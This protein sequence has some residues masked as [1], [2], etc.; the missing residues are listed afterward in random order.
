MSI[1]NKIE[2][3][4][5]LTSPLHCSTADSDKGKGDKNFT[6]TQKQYILTPNGSQQFPFFPGNDLRGRLR[7]KAAKIIMESLVKKSKISVDLYS[8]LSAGTIHASP[9]STLS[10]E[11][12]LRARDNVYMGLFGGGT[13]MLRSRYRVNDLI[14]VARGTVEA[15]V[16]PT[17]V[18]DFRATIPAG[19]I[20]E[21][22][23]GDLTGYQLCNTRTSFRI[24]DVTRV[25]SADDINKYI[26]DAVGAVAAKQADN[27]ASRAER[28]DS[29]AK[30]KD[31]EIPAR[32][33]MKKE[34]TSN[35][36]VVESIISGTDMHFLLDF[37]NDASDEHVGMMLLSLQDLVRE[38]GLGGWVRIGFGRFNADVVLTRNGRTYKIFKDGSN[39]ADATLTDEVMESFVNKALNAVAKLTA[40][41]LMEFFTNKKPVKE[42]DMP[43]PKKAG[44]AG[45]TAET[46]AA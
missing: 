44:K 18:A 29:K 26:K 10:M 34:E 7:R 15:G 43:A 23:S 6:N 40:E 27:L 21:N 35:M 41:D 25:L 19:R 17:E 1:N 5:H 11:E 37:E 38:Q 30:A 22:T 9:E 24:D 13:R 33:V 31:G 16:V 8:A 12:A 2:G 45:K 20:G 46:E 39:G 3:F 14:P 36:F 28:K 42:D 32:D 4:F